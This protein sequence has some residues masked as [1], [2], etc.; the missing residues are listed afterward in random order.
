[1]LI[2][3]I[4]IIIAAFVVINS[5]SSPA[6]DSESVEPNFRAAGQMGSQG[7]E[8]LN[9]RASDELVVAVGTHGG[10]PEAGFDPIT[11]WGNSR[12][13]LVQSTLFKRDSKANLINDLATDYTVSNDRLKWTVKIRSDVKFHDGMP[14][15]AKDVA[16]TFNTAANAGGSIDLSVLEKATAVDDYTVEFKLNDPQSTFINKLVALGIVP[17]HAYNVETYGSNPVGS[18]PYKFVQWDKGQQVIFEANPDYYGQEPYFKKL[19]MLFMGSDSAFAA[20]K[21]GQ[22]NLAEIPASYANQEVDGMKIISLDSIDARGISFPMNPNAGEKTENGYAIGND[23]TSDPAIRKALNIGIDRQALIEGA[24]NGQG[25][26]EFTGVDKLPWGNKEAVFEDGDI[27]G[28]KKI[29]SEGGWTDTDGDGIVEKNEL[30]AEFTLLYPANAQERQ[31]LAVSVSEE[32]KKLGINI[33]VEGKSWDEIYS[34]CYSTPNVW[35]YGSLDPTDIYLR[36]YS[37]SYDPSTQNN[38]IMYNNS[39]VDSYLRTAITSPDQ[40]TANKNWQLAAWDGTTG[41]SAKG[42]A[43]W[44]WMATIN[45]VYIMDEDLDIGAPKIQPHGADIFGSILEW[46]RA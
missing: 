17:E 16:F 36:Y 23:V 7:S 34:L 20:A 19:T 8:G 26:E 35:G 45:Y 4:I 32:A 25:K 37:K 24:L 3:S 6:A 1:M 44:M 38:V 2:G 43:S 27:E 13:P 28:A 46:K 42:D 22:V 41:F 33:K 30:K 31:A 9:S 39:A 15:T 11:G 5:M 10:E 12:E 21:A 29:L 40:E 14:L 18:G